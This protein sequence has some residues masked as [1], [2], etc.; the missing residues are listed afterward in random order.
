MTVPQS[1]QITREVFFSQTNSFLA[2]ILQLL[3]SSCPGRL[4]SRNSTWFNWTLFYNHFALTTQ[5]TQLFYCYKGVFTEP[6]HSNGSHLIVACVF[7]ATWMCLPSRCLA[8]NVYSKFTNPVF[9]RHA[10]V[11]RRC[12][13]GDK[14]C[15]KC[16]A[17]GRMRTERGNRNTRR[18]AML[19]PLHPP[20]ILHDVT[21]DLAQAAVVSSQQLTAWGKRKHNACRGRVYELH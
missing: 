21:L 4:A 20:Q 14:M 18:K 11:S 12:K 7:V 2:I 19:V 1:F 5:K 8:M 3:P 15:N 9:G 16:G 6:L 13:V 10:T 17:V